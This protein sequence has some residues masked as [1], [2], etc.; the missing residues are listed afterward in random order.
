MMEYFNCLFSSI[1]ESLGM[2]VYIGVGSSGLVEFVCVV[3][4]K[5]FIVI[6]VC[7]ELCGFFKRKVKEFFFIN[8]INEWVLLIG[9]IKWIVYFF[10]NLCYNLFCKFVVLLEEFLNLKFILE[11]EVIGIDIGNFFFNL[12]C[13]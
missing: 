9:C 1:K 5:K 13:E 3:K 4:F 7:S 8:V 10:N 6:E 11:E 2:V 12:V